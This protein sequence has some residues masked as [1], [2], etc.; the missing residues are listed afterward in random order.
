MITDS[1][2]GIAKIVEGSNSF[3][4]R[5]AMALLWAKVSFRAYHI[6]YKQQF[7]YIKVVTNK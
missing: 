4:H 2:S 1:N 3:A 6:H 5:F 7:Q